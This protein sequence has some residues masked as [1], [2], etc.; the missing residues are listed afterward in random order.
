MIH[1]NQRG[2]LNLVGKVII[3]LGAPGRCRWWWRRGRQG[4]GK[5]NKHRRW[6]RR[7]SLDK[8]RYMLYV[9]TRIGQ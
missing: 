1:R 2:P 8:G 4:R 7:G 6:G 5:Q 3:K 9:Q